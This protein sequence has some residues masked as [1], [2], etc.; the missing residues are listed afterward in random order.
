MSSERQRRNHYDVEYD[1]NLVSAKKATTGNT[2]KARTAWTISP[3]GPCMRLVSSI[4]LVTLCNQSE[5]WNEA[6]REK[7]PM[8]QTFPH[9]LKLTDTVVA[10]RRSISWSL[11]KK[12][13]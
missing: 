11:G 1:S 9:P 5:K 2:N 12:I 6:P 13:F 8:V 4:I 7:S 10:T 3:T